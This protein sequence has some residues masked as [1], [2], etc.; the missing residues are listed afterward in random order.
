MAKVRSDKHE[1]RRNAKEEQRQ[2]RGLAKRVDKLA[3]EIGEM[4]KVGPPRPEDVVAR[5]ARRG[6]RADFL[7]VR[8]GN[9]DYGGPVERDIRRLQGRSR[10]DLASDRERGA[11]SPLE[12]RKRR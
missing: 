10:A 6:E 9:A 2:E 5:Q 8:P 12:R 3:H 11:V 7:R 1:A 4:R